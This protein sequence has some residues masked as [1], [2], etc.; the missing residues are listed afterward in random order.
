MQCVDWNDDDPRLQYAFTLVQSGV[1][2]R[3]RIALITFHYVALY[4][5]QQVSILTLCVRVWYPSHPCSGLEREFKVTEF[6]PSPTSTVSLP[7]SPR[8]VGFSVVRCY[9]RNVDGVQTTVDVRVVVPFPVVSSGSQVTQLAVALQ[10]DLKDALRDGNINAFS[11]LALQ[12]TG[13]LSG[14]SE[15]ATGNLD[16]SARSTPLRRYQQRM[17]ATRGSAS[18]SETMYSEAIERLRTEQMLRH[19]QRADSRYLLQELTE[20]LSVPVM[21]FTAATTLSAVAPH[22]R[23]ATLARAFADAHS[24]ST[25]QRV[26]VLSTTL[27]VADLKSFANVRGAIVDYIQEWENNTASSYTPPSTVLTL[28]QIL[29][30]AFDPLHPEQL[31]RGPRLRAMQWVVRRLT[32]LM[33]TFPSAYVKPVAQAGGDG[34]LD[35]RAY[36]R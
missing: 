23:F 16:Q 9:V 28:M 25:T 4:C 33:P 13:L 30:S 32:T 1:G 29:A 34:A 35:L 36:T 27:T 12:V 8:D 21:Q 5:H 31:A 24:S 3:L 7:P 6:S 20:P 19:A 15:Q 14:S 26:G 22:G 11:G 10:D 17:A 18:T 2:G